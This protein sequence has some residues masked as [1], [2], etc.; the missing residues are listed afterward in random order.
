[1]LIASL[2]KPEIEIGRKSNKILKNIWG[3]L[4]FCDKC[5]KEISDSAISENTFCFYLDI[6][7][8]KRIW[9][10]KVKFLKHWLT[11]SWNLLTKWAFLLNGDKVIVVFVWHHSIRKPI[12][13][14]GMLLIYLPGSI[15]QQRSIGEGGISYQQIWCEMPF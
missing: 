10:N 3:V 7:S 13:G 12:I 2:S 11:I 15:F 9:L 1:M 8:A 4:W 5:L 14:W 6:Q